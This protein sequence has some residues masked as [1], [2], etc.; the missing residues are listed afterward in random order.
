R[1]GHVMDIDPI[2]TT[3]TTRLHPRRSNASGT[4]L[5]RWPGRALALG[6]RAPRWHRRR[7]GT[8]FFQKPPL[9]AYTERL[10]HTA[11]DKRE[12]RSRDRPLPRGGDV[13]WDDGDR[14]GG[15]D[16]DRQGAERD[17][18]GELPGP[19]GRHAGVAG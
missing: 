1:P 4:R 7:A 14:T 2:R 15:L 6:S 16:A 9:T 5:S 13:F 11:G 10:V 8:R 18:D 3:P 17:A 19:D 12:R